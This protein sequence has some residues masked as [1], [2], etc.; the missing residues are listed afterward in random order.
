MSLTAIVSYFSHVSYGVDKL[1]KR[2]TLARPLF[3]ETDCRELTYD[4]GKVL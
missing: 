1:G 2:D 3:M 4:I